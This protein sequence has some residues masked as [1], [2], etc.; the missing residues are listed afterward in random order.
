MKPQW[1]SSKSSTT[2]LYI[3]YPTQTPKLGHVA[4]KL[5]QIMKNN[6]ECT[7][8]DESDEIKN[9]YS[10]RKKA[11]YVYTQKI[12]HQKK[13]SEPQW[14]Y[15]VLQKDLRRKTPLSPRR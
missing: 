14:G 12:T 4:K 11:A 2:Q 7:S 6:A 9:E 5:I 10:L 15:Q 8:K 3:N 13:G 1:P